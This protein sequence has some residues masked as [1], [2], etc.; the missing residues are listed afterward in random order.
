MPDSTDAVLDGL[1]G[2]TKNVDLFVV[3]VDTTEAYPGLD[4]RHM[5]TLK[6]HFAHLT[7]LEAAG[8]LL[9]GGPID[10]DPGHTGKDSQ[11]MHIF[12]ASS[13]DEVQNFIEQD[14]FTQRGWTTYSIHTW[15]VCFGAIAGQLR[16]I[17]GQL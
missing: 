16:E 5:E 3:F 8:S 7:T 17:V 6:D 2:D 12:R 15:L 10:F 14:P 9:S 1:L 4:E 13:R 11:A